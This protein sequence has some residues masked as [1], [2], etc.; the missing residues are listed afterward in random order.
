MGHKPGVAQWQSNPAK[1]G[2]DAIG[3]IPASRTIY[4]LWIYKEIYLRYMK[5]IH[6][7]RTFSRLYEAEGDAKV[8]DFE[9]IIRLTLANILD[10]YKRIASLTVDPDKDPMIKNFESVAKSADA[11]K[12]LRRVTL[13][14][15]KDVKESAKKVWG[16]W[17]GTA[18]SF[19]SVLTKIQEMM[20]NNKEAINKLVQDYVTQAKDNLLAASKENVSKSA[21]VNAEKQNESEEFIF[22]G[23][24]EGKKKKLKQISQQITAA[25]S[26]LKD[27]ESIKLIAGDIPPLKSELDK[28][29]S[30]VAK[31]FGMKNKEI[32]DE[33]IENYSTQISE[34]V[35]KLTNKQNELAK[36]NDVTKEA[37]V[38]FSQ[39]L[40]KFAEAAKSESDYRASEAKKQEDETKAKQEGEKVNQ[41]K[42]EVKALGLEET[43]KQAAVKGKKN[44][45]VAKV[46]TFITKNLSDKIKG[47]ESFKKFSEGKYAGDG[48]FGD[49]TAKVIKGIKAGYG[50]KDNSSDI[51]QELVSYAGNP[52]QKF[53]LNKFLEIAK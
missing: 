21:A 36:E 29:S 4:F 48:F 31:M 3:S 20:P 18:S 2:R 27:L 28:I 46:Q 52:N 51:T 16:K 47:S 24:L 34:L 6:D 19:L 30:E 26:T 35:T 13:N 38:L 45:V 32:S 1:T 41:R 25:D 44:T 17:Q 23:F 9:N 7:F 5:K 15:P 42:E 14:V 10:I 8:S 22:E 43:I 37:A 39:A 11:V 49:N 33:S 40:T 50:L 12:E 53:D